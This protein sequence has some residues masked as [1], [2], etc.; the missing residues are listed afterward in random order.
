MNNLNLSQRK[1]QLITWTLLALIPIIGMAVDLIAPALPDISHVLHGSSSIVQNTI[2]LYL[3]GYGLGNFISGILTDVFGRRKLL[4]LG[5]LG[6]ILVSLSAA[7]IPN[8]EILLVTR[9]LQGLT[10]GTLAVSTRAILSDILDAQKLV[11]LGVMI[12]MM[13]GIGP[14]IGPIIGGYLEE[15]FG[16]EAGFYFFSLVG[17]LGL[18]AVF[19]IVPETCINTHPLKI[20]ILKQNFREL[21]THHQFIGLSALM[22][23]NYSLMIIFN[24]AGPFLIQNRFH[25]SAVQF[26]DIALALGIVYVM[27]TLVCRYLLT[28]YDA[29]QLLFTAVCIFLA[30][31]IFAVGI[32]YFL[33]NNILFIT[34]ISGI[35]FFATGFIFPL[36]MGSGMSLFRHIAGS[37]TA[38]MYLINTAI[39]SISAALLSL[40]HMQTGIPLIWTYLFLTSISALVYLILVR[41][42]NQQVQR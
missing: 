35:M 8:V 38:T 12:G 20:N 24:T 3:I 19:L 25:Y 15:Y 30:I 26:G 36:S 7:I 18:I 23:L 31:A 28:K 37:A 1:T 16:W 5:L 41:K 22:G 6:F 29:K 9:F 34:L 2:S 4:L 17:S 10:L 27:G 13:W 21:I 39:T 40:V 14:V 42:A 11:A 33:S 32:V